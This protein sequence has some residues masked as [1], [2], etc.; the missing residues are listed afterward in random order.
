MSKN[1]FDIKSNSASTKS[2]R[3]VASPRQVGSPRR[4]NARSGKQSPRQVGSPNQ[5]TPEK[6]IYKKYPSTKYSN[7]EIKELLDGYNEVP[8]SAWGQI[9]VG[10]H[11]RYFKTDGKFVRG[12]FVINHWAKDGKDFIHLSNNTKTTA[13]KYAAWPVAHESVKRIFK[14]PDPQS[15]I[16][17]DT[18]RNKTLEIITQINK[19]VSAIKKLQQ[20]VDEQDRQIAYLK[21]RR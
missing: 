19:L 15:K 11:I 20:R 5:N 10:S 6:K 9:P 12:G 13:P 2:P 1:P 7:D 4:A 16:E 17:V 21:S 3:Q 8:R 18:M 14:K